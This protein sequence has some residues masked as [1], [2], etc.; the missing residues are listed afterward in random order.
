MKK[1]ITLVMGTLL[2]IL[3][4]V[5]IGLAEDLRLLKEWG[6]FTGFVSAVADT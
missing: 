6:V 4:T 2:I 5:G 3:S 1:L